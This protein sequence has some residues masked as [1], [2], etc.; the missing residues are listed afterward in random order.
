M[1]RF[2]LVALL[3]FSLNV[4]IAQQTNLVDEPKSE[5]LGLMKN[6][7]TYLKKEFYDLK[8]LGGEW[9]VLIITNVLENTKTGYIRLE[10]SHYSSVSTSS[11][12]GFFDFDEIDMCIKYLEYIKL[13]MQSLPA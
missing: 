13:E 4:A 10:T 12:V 1:K 5:I 2:Y 8:I 9:K 11:Y 7:G 6:D 3:L